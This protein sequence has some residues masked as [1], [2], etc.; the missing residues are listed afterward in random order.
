MFTKETTKKL[1][2]TDEPRT[3][4]INYVVYVSDT[5]IPLLIAQIYGNWLINIIFTAFDQMENK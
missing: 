3:M 5:K 1:L 4:M 2:R